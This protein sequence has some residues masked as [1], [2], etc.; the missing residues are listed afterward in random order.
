[1]GSKLYLERGDWKSGV[2]GFSAEP[3]VALHLFTGSVGYSGESKLR[4]C[5][6][7]RVT[8]S[9][10]SATSSFELANTKPATPQYRNS[11]GK[12]SELY[13]CPIVERLRRP[14][15]MSQPC[16]DCL[17][18]FCWSEVFSWTASARYAVTGVVVKDWISYTVVAVP[19]VRPEKATLVTSNSIGRG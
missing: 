10:G 11:Y 6:V 4:I 7:I 9:S 16:V 1:M 5:M 12:W 17:V 19:L 13:Q 8:A 18:F 3:A 14:C 2:L 15:L